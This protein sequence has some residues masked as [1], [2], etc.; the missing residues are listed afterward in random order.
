MKNI[1]AALICEFMKLNRSGIFWIT[2]VL[3]IFIP[4]MFGLMM[5]ISQ[6]PDLISKMGIVGTKAKLFGENDWNGY[7][8]ILNQSIA[9]IGLIAFGFVTSWIFGSEYT[10]RTMKDLLA[11]PV[12]RTSIV[13]AKFLVTMA[14]CALLAIIYISV[15]LLAGKIVGIP[16]W[17]SERTAE[18]LHRFFSIAFLTMLLC[19]PVGFFAGYGRG[20]L[21]PLGFVIVTLIL[22]Q[23]MGI[24]GLG[25][26][27]PWAIPGVYSVGENVP[28]MILTK[29]SYIILILTFLAGFACT[30]LWWK[31]ADHH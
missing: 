17:E 11:L 14:W 5:Y 15:A 19:T 25:P 8:G 30:A 27:F 12:S 13:I 20:I 3:F 4:T 22:A 28:G 16:G 1:K 18:F 10:N 7:F 24:S 23:F 6:H 21:A 29:T 2:I 31:K 9:T 26:Y